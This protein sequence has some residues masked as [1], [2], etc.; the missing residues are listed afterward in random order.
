MPEGTH[1]F[2]AGGRQKKDYEELIYSWVAEARH[3]IPQDMILRSFLKCGISNSLDGTEDDLVQCIWEF[4]WEFCWWTWFIQELFM[5]DDEE[6]DYEGFWNLMREL[7]SCNCSSEN[8][9]TGDQVV[10]TSWCF[11]WRGDRSNELVFAVKGWSNR[12]NELVFPGNGWSSRSNE[13]VFP[14]NGWPSPSN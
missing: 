1:E 7:T 5:S 2:S 12:S 6:S 13:L 10:R 3:D 4:S 8:E 9:R 14:A 11:R